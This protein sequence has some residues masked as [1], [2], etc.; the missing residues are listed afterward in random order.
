MKEDSLSSP[1]LIAVSIVGTAADTID[2]VPDTGGHR[3]FRCLCNYLHSLLLNVSPF[4]TVG[5]FSGE[6]E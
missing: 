6:R 2:I 5:I 3:T 1:P 4:V